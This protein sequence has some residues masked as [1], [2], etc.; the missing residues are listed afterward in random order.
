MGAAVDGGTKAS[1]PFVGGCGI[2]DDGVYVEAP[3]GVEIIGDPY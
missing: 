1:C 2:L 3:V